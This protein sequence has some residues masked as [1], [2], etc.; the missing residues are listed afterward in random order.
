MNYLLTLKIFSKYFGN[1]YHILLETI[2]LFIICQYICYIQKI[3]F[4]I[5]TVKLRLYY[6][7]KD[8]RLEIMMDFGI[9][10]MK[11]GMINN[12]F[13][14]FFIFVIKKPIKAIHKIYRRLYV[15]RVHGIVSNFFDRHFNNFNIFSF[16]ASTY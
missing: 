13:F 9:F 14:G 4:L 7:D 11:L 12:C 5:S 10:I 3:T 16:F 8:K 6:L 1:L 2:D 15:I